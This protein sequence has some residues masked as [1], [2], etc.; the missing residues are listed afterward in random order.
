[1][2]GWVVTADGETRV[3]LLAWD[4][5]DAREF[6]VARIRTAINRVTGI[7]AS[8]ILISATHNHSGPKSEMGTSRASAREERTSRPAPLRLGMTYTC[9][10]VHSGFAME[11]ACAGRR[12]FRR[13]GG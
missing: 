9:C 2:L 6:A 7:P 13:E 10:Q 1:M 12:P 5:L 3:A 8:H 11:H 4:L